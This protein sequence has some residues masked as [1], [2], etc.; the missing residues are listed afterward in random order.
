MVISSLLER[1]GLVVMA[2]WELSQ[3]IWVLGTGT[4]KTC[5]VELMFYIGPTVGAKCSGRL[6]GIVFARGLSL[7]AKAPSFAP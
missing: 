3:L 4:E 6:T 2:F 5:V 7:R 1:G